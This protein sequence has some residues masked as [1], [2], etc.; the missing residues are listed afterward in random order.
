MQTTTGK[1]SIDW[2]VKNKIVLISHPEHL[3]YAVAKPCFE[4]MY[5]YLGKA[6]HRIHFISDLSKVRSVSLD[7]NKCFKLPVL[8]QVISHRNLGM[9]ALI[10]APSYIQ[11]L[12]G[13]LGMFGRAERDIIFFSTVKEA[14]EYL[15]K[16]PTTLG[17]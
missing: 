7:C 17:S 13:M 3:T 4:K 15:L 6:H 11:F 12:V 8:Q 2:A 16:Q 10:N 9:H 1:S 14:K 5:Q